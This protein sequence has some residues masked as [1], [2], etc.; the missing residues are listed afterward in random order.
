MSKCSPFTNAAFEMAEHKLPILHKVLIAIK[1]L[2]CGN[3]TTLKN[4][5]DKIEADIDSHSSTRRPKNLSFLVKK[6][7]LRATEDGSINCKYKKYYLTPSGLKLCRWCDKRGKSKKGRSRRKSSQRRKRRK[8]KLPKVRRCKQLVA[9]WKLK[10]AMS[11]KSHDPRDNT[12]N[13]EVNPEVRP[14]AIEEIPMHLQSKRSG[15][16]RRRSRRKSGGRRRSRSKSRGRRRSRSKSRERW[17][18]LCS[19]ERGQEAGSLHDEDDDNEKKEEAVE[20]KDFW[21]FRCWFSQ[22]LVTILRHFTS[23]VVYTTLCTTT[24]RLSPCTCVSSYL[25]HFVYKFLL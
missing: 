10:N 1:N 18:T 5:M 11:C 23:C 6:A 20:G 25:I 22:L 9:R 7:L 8:S 24:F 13:S 4:I 3:G 14:E 15:S 12:E 16:E 21:K 19:S 17:N 2:K